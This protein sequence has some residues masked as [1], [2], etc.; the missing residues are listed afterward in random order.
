MRDDVSTGEDAN[1]PN[2]IIIIVDTLRKDY[3]K[4]LEKKLKDLGFVSYDNVIA[5]ASWTTPSHASI[6]T[7]CYPMFHGAHETKN[8]KTY[9]VKLE[10]TKNILSKELSDLGY[11]TYLLSSNPY[12]RPGSGFNGFDFFYDTLFTPK[13]IFLSRKEVVSK[14]GNKYNKGETKILKAI[15]SNKN[16]KVSIKTILTYIFNKIY[17]TYAKIGK[18]WPLDK[19]ATSILKYCSREILD[20]NITSPKFLFINFMEVHAPYFRG[21]IGRLSFYVNINKK[22]REKALS[23][24]Y[25]LKFK[26]SYTKEVSYITE[27]LS[28]C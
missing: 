1:K 28:N 13:K 18:K 9:K 22:L 14:L 20:K 15:T 19:G 12:I 5:P 8:C 23:K 4:T 10:K 26:K 16:H 6:F 27:K 17:Y 25:L 3:S 11:V 24:K 21:E 2:I 7:G